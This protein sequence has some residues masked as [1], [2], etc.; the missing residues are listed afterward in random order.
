MADLTVSGADELRLCLVGGTTSATDLSAEGSVAGSGTVLAWHSDDGDG[1]GTRRTVDLWSMRWR[2][3]GARKPY[4]VVVDDAGCADRDEVT[5]W[6]GAADGEPVGPVEVLLDED[7]LT[8]GSATAG[9]TRVD[10][11]AWDCAGDPS[12]WGTLVVRAELG[13][14]QSGGSA[15]T[16]S[17]S[18]LQVSLDTNGQASVDWTVFDADN[19]GEPAIHAG[20]SN[21]AAHGSATATV[22]GDARRPF[23]VE[24]VPVGQTLA[25]WDT[26]VLRASEPLYA[27]GVTSSVVELIDPTGFEVGISSIAL[28]DDG[29]LIT[30]T[31]DAPIDG[32]LG[33]YTL[34]LDQS[35]RDEGGGNRLDGAWTGSASDLTVEIGDVTVT[36]PDITSCASNLTRFRPDGDPGAGVD[37]DMVEVAV[38]ADSTPALWWMVVTD[39]AGNAVLWQPTA[40]GAASATLEWDGRGTSGRVLQAGAYNIEISGRDANFVQGSVCSVWVDVEHPISAPVSP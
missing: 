25:S 23:V 9:G 40:G 19:G 18:G 8:A 16:A 39:S 35:L 36:A 14:I 38:I 32:S 13:H 15:V 33:I 28:S 24:L 22:S 30:I 11:A 37:A 21:G 31:P 20:V 34:A 1:A 29:Q 10:L 6:V 26:L 5:V 7:A 4:V 3:S 27:P 12:R 2:S 17:G